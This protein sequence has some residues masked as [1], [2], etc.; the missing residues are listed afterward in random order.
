MT[1]E[2]Y[3]ATEAALMDVPEPVRR[4][5]PRNVNIALGLVGGGVLLK[6]LMTIRLFIE[7]QL[8]ITNPALLAVP[9]GG[10]IL[11]G[12]IC[13]QIAHGRSWARLLLLLLTLFVFAQLCWAIGYIWR[14]APEMWDLMLDSHFV[15]T[16]ILPLA[17]N[18]G[19]LHLLYFSSGDWF[20]PP[21]AG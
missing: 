1:N 9:I 17:M 7:A 20:G 3:K 16:R 11:M 19:A 2:N 14:Q 13:H 6:V 21:K 5:R 12:V 15:V 18:M 8:Q 4:A 10:L